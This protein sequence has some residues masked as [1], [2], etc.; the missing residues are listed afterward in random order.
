MNILLIGYGKMG[1]AVEKTALQRG[2]HVV[3]KISA[4]NKA[5]LATVEAA[6]VNV[7]IEFSEPN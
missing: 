7:A 2:H 1:R 6:T 3:Q 4:K 5:A